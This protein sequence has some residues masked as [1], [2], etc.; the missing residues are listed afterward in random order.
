MLEDGIV[1]HKH[2]LIIHIDGSCIHIED[3]TKHLTI[4]NAAYRAGKVDFVD[5]GLDC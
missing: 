3:L 2:T 1:V 5:T 4:I